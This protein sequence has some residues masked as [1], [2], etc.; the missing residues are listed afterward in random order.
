MVGGSVDCSDNST[1]LKYD[2]CYNQVSLFSGE[3]MRLSSRMEGM[4]GTLLAD[5]PDHPALGA[6]LPACP[7]CTVSGLA[8]YG[9]DDA[10]MTF[11]G[12]TD[13]GPNQGEACTAA[14]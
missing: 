6:C 12:V 11:L 7:I 14:C 10:G 4:G 9:T 13:R 5:S 1:R 2:V 3:G 8:V